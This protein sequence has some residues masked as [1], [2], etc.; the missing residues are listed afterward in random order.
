[1]AKKAA[2]IQLKQDQIAQSQF[3]QS[4]LQDQLRQS[5]AELAVK[6][7]QLS[8]SQMRQQQLLE[9]STKLQNEINQKQS[10]LSSMNEQ[11]K[12][13]NTQLQALN[14]QNQS[15]TQTVNQVKQENYQTL[16]TLTE[17]QIAL[18]REK[19]DRLAKAAQRV[20][21]LEQKVLEED[22]LVDRVGQLERSTTG[23]SML[24]STTVSTPQRMSRYSSTMGVDQ[25]R[26]SI[27]NVDTMRLE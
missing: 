22:G 4:Q 3:Q 6:S 5:R 25:L 21:F 24:G 10:Q 16:N 18:E 7:E 27:R 19:Q 12:L 8:A 1:M 15:L 14:Y 23:N 13:L 11:T 17:A 20:G 9:Q 2:D 26:E